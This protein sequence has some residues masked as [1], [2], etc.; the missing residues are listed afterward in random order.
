[1]NAL[2]ADLA[3]GAMGPAAME[4][5]RALAPLAAMTSGLPCDRHPDCGEVPRHSRVLSI[6]L[7]ANEDTTTGI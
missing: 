5:T 7:Q 4:A 3:V 1:M 2:A 6:R